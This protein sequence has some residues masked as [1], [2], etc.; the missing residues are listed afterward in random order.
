M[1]QLEYLQRNAT[2]TREWE[3]GKFVMYRLT[4]GIAIYNKHNDK[5]LWYT[6][7]QPR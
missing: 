4:E 1:T 2:S 5:Y 7:R 6:N 3:D